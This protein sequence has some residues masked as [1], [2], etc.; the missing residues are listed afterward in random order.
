MVITCITS[1]YERVVAAASHSTSSKEKFNLLVNLACSC[2]LI[3]DNC[4]TGDIISRAKCPAWTGDVSQV[5]THDATTGGGW[6]ECAEFRDVMVRNIAAVFEAARTTYNS[7]EHFY[8]TNATSIMEAIREKLNEDVMDRIQR[9]L[10]RYGDLTNRMYEDT[11][12]MQELGRCFCEAE[13]MKDIYSHI[14]HL[15]RYINE[16]TL[17]TTMDSHTSRHS[18]RD[19]YPGDETLLATSEKA[20][21]NPNAA[22]WTESQVNLDYQ[23]LTE[24]AMEILK[25]A[26]IALI[27]TDIGRRLRFQ[28]VQG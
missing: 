26:Y 22:T 10:G 27:S 12:I 20:Y 21:N 24:K 4:Y 13:F 25:D 6:N 17:R 18:I 5:G 8:V 19:H 23:P 9:L 2:T 7:W 15:D 14:D 28:V 3:L 16:I 1:P 11:V